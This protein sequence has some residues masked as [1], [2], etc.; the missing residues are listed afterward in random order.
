MDRVPSPAG[1]N[2]DSH[3]GAPAKLFSESKYLHQKQ[4]LRAVAVVQQVDHIKKNQFL[5]DIRI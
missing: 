3:V 5:D 4:S 2:L 1:V